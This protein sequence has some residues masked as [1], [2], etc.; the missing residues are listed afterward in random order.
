MPRLYGVRTIPFGLPT[1]KRRIW[2][3]GLALF[4]VALGS[5][6]GYGAAGRHASYTTG[7][8]TARVGKLEH[9]PTDAAK[10]VS[11]APGKAEATLVEGAEVPAGEV[12]T[13]EHTRAR[14][15]GADGT[16]FAMDRSTSLWTSGTRSFRLEKGV[17]LAS[18]VDAS[19]AAPA[20]F[21]TPVGSVLVASGRTKLEITT[22][23]D[24]THVE[25][26]RGSVSV[27]RSGAAPVE[28][29][30]GQEAVMTSALVDLAPAG[31]LA[32]RMA[33]AESIGVDVSHNDD[34]D[35]AM[36]AL[37]E[38]RARKPG[39]EAEKDR[40]VRLARH[41]VKVRI[42]GGMARTEVDETFE[43]DSGDVLE[44]VYRFP[45]PAG[46]Q[47]ERL[48]LEVD[49]KLVDGAFVDKDKGQAIWRGAIHNAAPQAPRPREDIVWV[50]GPWRDPALL[51]WQR[52]GRFE[53]KIFPIPKQ[54]KRRVVLA[55]T[56]A[57]V[58]VAGHRR[59]VYPLPAASNLAPFDFFVDVR[60]LGHDP[61]VP[62]TVA[63]Y[64]LDRSPIDQGTAFSRDLGKTT[65][66]GDLTVEYALADDAREM[67]A[68][69]YADEADR[70][71]L[72]AL[73]PKLPT[74]GESRPR[75]YVIVVDSGRAMFGE[76]SKRAARLAI[77]LAEELDR[78]DRV[79]VLACDVSC[80]R[81][82]G[83]MKAAGSPTA[84]DVDAF[85]ATVTPDGASDLG[86][87][88]RQ[89]TASPDPTRDLRVVLLS[90][91]AASAG[92]RTA[93][94]LSR[95][96]ASV[97]GPRDSLVTV[98]IGSDAD[99]QTLQAMA[100]AGGGAMVAYAPGE[101]LEVAALQVL[102]AT[103]GKTLRD[104]RLTLPDGITAAA[105]SAIH[106]IFSGSE[107]LVAGKLA[108]DHVTG[109]VVL[110][111]T[112]AGEPFSLTLPLDVTAVR[113]QGNAFVPREFAS[114]AIHDLEKGGAA[115]RA[116]AVALSQRYAVPS[117]FTSL[118]VLESE[119]MFQ[120]FGVSRTDRAAT[121]TGEEAA[122]GSL[123]GG[124]ESSLEAN[125]DSDAL[126]GLLGAGR[127]A[128]RATAA[129]GAGSSA[130]GLFANPFS[131]EATAEAKKAAPAPTAT[132]AP[133]APDA[134][135]QGPGLGWGRRAPGRFMKRVWHREADV[136]A[137]VGE[138]I[139]FE[140]MAD[141]RAK[142]AASPDERQKTIDLVRALERTGNVTD[143]AAT[144]DAWQKRDA[145]DDAAIAARADLLAEQGHREDALRVR[146]G[147]VSSLRAQDPAV[148]D[149]LAVA[150]ERASEP[151][152]AC[153]MRV[154]AAEMSPAEDRVARAIRCERARGRDAEAAR[155]LDESGA[156]RSLV[157]ASLARFDADAG[158]PETPA[159]DVVIDASWNDADADLDLA[160]VDPSGARVSWLSSA[161]FVKVSDP[162]S[163]AH[164]ALSVTSGAAGAFVVE[165]VRAS[166]QVDRTVRGTLSVR[167]FGMK[168][169]MPFEVSGT[170]ARVARIDARW[171]SELVPVDDPITLAAH[172][173]FDSAAASRAVSAVSV[174][175]CHDTVG[176]GGP[177]TVFVTFA[178]SGRVLS[179][180]TRGALSS[181]ASE[182]V[183]SAFRSLVVP[184]FD[185]SSAMVTRRVI[186]GP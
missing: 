74:W 115:R 73:R 175:Q 88:V 58:P 146:S 65:P 6:I 20:T 55:Y 162:T 85:L 37:G 186:V 9:A 60:V 118:L 158:K 100:E 36:G 152:F 93:E 21:S 41:S 154:T 181:G 89:A 107:L 51:E 50:P 183:S 148:V 136:G 46:A 185:S 77:Q 19:D 12:W 42:A 31:D 18:V 156:K 35:P 82:P 63:G 170:S 130:G 40:A 44:G 78:R 120:A 143:L 104:V 79:T 140:K 111:G 182:C 109:D 169:T 32:Q 116:E 69:G 142:S 25:V 67:T 129:G 94:H 39:E 137:S 121:W 38:L 34:A 178:G 8:W 84:H 56:E 28:V 29:L 99:T 119:A 76:R 166:G 123:A 102:A 168:K 10:L 5:V 164:E 30:A 49:D 52:G 133:P 172:T 167:A 141:L 105:P 153:A 176:G 108:S 147:L 161:R 113:T 139:S 27:T 173:P 62:V 57:I 15:D 155:W 72:L 91:G 53:L 150:F 23:P 47:I 125:K 149:A 75:D 103:Y 96:V 24:R 64:E 110:S 48:A 3:S 80:A 92:Y 128:S 180:V 159:G 95:E 117:A 90:E 83:G 14:V 61:S 2:L 114:L 132:A 145:L 122:S 70:Y 26:L 126:D 59:Y 112:L 177:A 144:V 151:G 127:T 43:N 171:E 101:K 33:F 134:I 13:D 97:V 81:M 68:W 17:I 11:R 71:A 16:S 86:E 157:T 165:V 124:D 135:A 66:R 138:I 98:P 54:G 179:A 174:A 4:G 106:P 45:L 184:A 22:T 163:H 1:G 87:A 131:D 7:G 160:L